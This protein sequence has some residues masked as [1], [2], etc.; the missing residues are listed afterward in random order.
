MN[1]FYCKKNMYRFRIR[2]MHPVCYQCVTEKLAMVWCCI[3][4]KLGNL[5]VNATLLPNETYRVWSNVLPFM[6]HCFHE[7]NLKKT[8]SNKI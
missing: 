3:R 4:V 7:T 6:L 8:V 2:Y 5:H 1:L